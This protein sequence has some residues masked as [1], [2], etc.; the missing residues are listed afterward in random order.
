MPT[1]VI[2]IVA[3]AITALVLIVVAPWR[4]VRAEPPLPPEVQARLLMG[5]APSEVAAE[6]DDEPEH[7]RVANPAARPDPRFGRTFPP[8]AG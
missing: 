2:I 6:L 4:R 1:A 3:L 5:D 8:R 7:L